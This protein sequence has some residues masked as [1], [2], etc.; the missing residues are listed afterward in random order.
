MTRSIHALSGAALLTAAIREPGL[1]N[2]LT[3]ADPRS[4]SSAA[5][6]EHDERREHAPHDSSRFP[7]TKQVPTT[8][9]IPMNHVTSPSGTGPMWPIPHPPTSC[10]CSWGTRP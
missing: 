3:T 6:Q 10:G 7:I 4:T 2:A 9:A 8:T 1:D 5:E